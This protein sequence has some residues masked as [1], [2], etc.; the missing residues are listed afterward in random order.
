MSDNLR[1]YLAILGA[2]KQLCPSEPQGN[3]LRHLHTLAQLIS[4]IVG[5]RR[6]NLPQVASKM[7]GGKQRE[8]RI[9]RLSRWLANERVSKKAFFTPFASALLSGLPPGPLVLV[10]DG[11]EMGR[12]CLALVVS[13]LF[14]KRA[15]PLCWIVVKGKKGHF[16][17]QAH[18]ALLEQVAQQVPLGRHVIFLGDG[19]FDGCG[20]LAA[21]RAQGW[22]FAC[23]TAKN[24]VLA[25]EAECFTFADL[26]VAPGELLSVPD[27]DFTAQNFGPVTVVAYWGQ[28]Y[29]EPL[30]LVTNLELADDALYWYGQRFGIETLFSDVKSRGFHLGHC[31]VSDPKRVSRLLIGACL[32]YLWIVYLGASVARKPALLR[33]IH[34]RGRCDLSLFQIGMAWLDEC[35]DTGAQIIV[36]FVMPPQKSV[37]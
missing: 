36:A 3:Y 16:P 28:D 33:R 23:R 20:L 12:G 6:T 35:L 22:E 10:M 8:S 21:V 14:Q 9:K 32:A 19:E 25:Q 18:V 30:Y 29:K 26:A 27:V 2:L 11:S 13:V 24:A 15:L 4:G 34:R 5:S 17:E 31:R 37:R 7:P 1:R